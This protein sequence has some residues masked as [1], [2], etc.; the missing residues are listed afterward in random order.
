MACADKRRGDCGR[1]DE[2]RSDGGRT[3]PRKPPKDR[4]D[5]TSRREIGADGRSWNRGSY[6]ETA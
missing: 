4:D 1:R 6:P 5:S 3:R 2:L